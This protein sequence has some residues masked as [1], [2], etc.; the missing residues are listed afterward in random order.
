[1]IEIKSD[2]K[3]KEKNFEELLNQFINRFDQ[4]IIKIGEV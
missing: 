2:N 3:I 4:K 1:M